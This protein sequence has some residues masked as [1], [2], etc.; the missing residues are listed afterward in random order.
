METKALHPAM[1]APNHAH[2]SR[3]ASSRCGLSPAHQSPPEDSAIA[4]RRS[5]ASA[6]EQSHLPLSAIVP[7]SR[8]VVH[9]PVKA[10]VR[11]V[12]GIPAT[13]CILGNDRHVLTGRC[14]VG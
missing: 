11:R 6:Q 9:D 12:E 13:L 2:G 7:R 3:D 14:V 5:L 1:G 10:S 4:K 8:R